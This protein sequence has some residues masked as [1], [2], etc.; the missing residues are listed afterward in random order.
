MWQ[1]K[2]TDIRRPDCPFIHRLEE[3][4]FHCD[5]IGINALGYD[6]IGEDSEDFALRLAEVNG[7]DFD[8]ITITDPSNPDLPRYLPT[9]PKG[10][11]KLFDGYAPEYVAVSLKD[12][13]SAH[14]LNVITDIHK[15]LGVPKKTKIILLGFGKDRLIERLWP[16]EIRSR[17]IGEIAK[18]NFY[19]VV[20]PNY[21]IW[22]DQPHAE[23]LINQKRSVIMYKELA[24]AGVQAVPHV[25]WCGRKDLDEYV[26]FLERHP[27]IKTIAIDM[28]TLGRNSDWRQAVAD[29]GYFAS[30]INSDT[31]CIIVGPSTPARIEQIIDILPNVTVVNSTAAQSAVRRRH[32]ADDLTK[33]LLLDVDK[34]DLMRTND[35]T[36]KA[37]VDSAFE[38]GLVVEEAT[39]AV[40]LRL[41]SDMIQQP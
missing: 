24:E 3:H 16:P 39:A 8:D 14:E 30:K 18:L 4:D 23:R 9:I 5:A 17:V 33:T 32:L 7:I 25:Y 41:S 20:P 19:A 6:L 21:S 26:R 1:L 40:G 11:R 13:V 36:I 31:R 38:A 27:D 15:R 28:Q 37:V 35:L 22:D 10:S 34:T 29:L 2:I 12:V